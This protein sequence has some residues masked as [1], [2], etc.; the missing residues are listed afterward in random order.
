MKFK[1]IQYNIRT[2]FRKSEEP[3]DLIIS[4]VSFHYV[5]NKAKLL[6]EIWRVLKLGGRAFLYIDSGYRNKS[7]DLL[8]LYLET[9]RFI[10]YKNGMIIKL[11][12]HLKIFRKKGFKISGTIFNKNYDKLTL[13]IEKN[14]LIPLKL[15][16]KYDG[17]STLY[18]TKLKDSDNYKNQNSIWWGDKKC[19]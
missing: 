13:M 8:K 2:G 5:G 11:S 19:L 1:I 18:L 12:Q 16:L 4:Q 17:N 14:K 9:P 7:P 3:F 10:I 15:N 6:E